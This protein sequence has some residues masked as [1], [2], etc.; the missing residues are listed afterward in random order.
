MFNFFRKKIV[1]NS[2]SQSQTTKYTVS[3]TIIET[4]SFQHTAGASVSIGTSFSTGVPFLAEGKI[5][6]EVTA[7]YE[8]SAGYS[9]LYTKIS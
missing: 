1:R 6:V 4:S 5:E 7:S 9:N 2:S 8:Y 3:R